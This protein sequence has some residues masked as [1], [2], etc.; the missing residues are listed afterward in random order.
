MTASNRWIRRRSSWLEV[1][2]Q[3]REIRVQHV[4]R[5]DRT[6]GLTTSQHDIIREELIGR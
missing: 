6:I 3:L 2:P 1:G 5:L 4:N